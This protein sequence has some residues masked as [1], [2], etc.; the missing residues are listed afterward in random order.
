MVIALGGAV[1]SV[2]RYLLSNG[3]YLWLGRGFPYGTLLVNIVGSFLI[4]LL[5]ETLILQRIT[6]AL[7]YRAAI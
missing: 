4:G 6:V 5:S 1:G 3:I 7:D 2:L